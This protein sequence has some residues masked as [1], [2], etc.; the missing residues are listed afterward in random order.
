MSTYGVSCSF[1]HGDGLFAF[2]VWR[3][4]WLL[5]VGCLLQSFSLCPFGQIYFGSI[6]IFVLAIMFIV[7]FDKNDGPLSLLA[8]YSI[9]QCIFSTWFDSC[10]MYMIMMIVM[11][12]VL[13]IFR[14]W[15]LS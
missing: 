3:E 1:W 9:H 7:Q 2:M 10:K 14:I 15:A 8:D 12:V 4:T 5:T 13:D 6:D 11:V